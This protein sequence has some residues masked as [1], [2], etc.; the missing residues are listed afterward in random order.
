MFVY[1]NFS[2]KIKDIKHDIS[3]HT[4]N[5]RI[6]EYSKHKLFA[7]HKSFNIPHAF[8]KL[9]FK[10]TRRC[11]KYWLSIFDNYL[12]H[13]NNPTCNEFFFFH[14]SDRHLH[15]SKDYE[16][17][18][19]V[20]RASLPLSTMGNFL[21]I[22]VEIRE[23]FL[24]ARIQTG[25]WLQLLCPKTINRTRPMKG[26]EY[27]AVAVIWV[28]DRCWSISPDAA[29]WACPLVLAEFGTNTVEKHLA[30]QWVGH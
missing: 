28:A 22:I 9:T 15:K 18:A 2:L 14:A 27:W 6:L 29:P 12:F 19:F 7:V 20:R 13:L 30:S 11:Q 8:A 5:I 21:Y 10:L 23:L 26:K 1:D 4:S 17:F 24:V 16:W 3:V 25:Q